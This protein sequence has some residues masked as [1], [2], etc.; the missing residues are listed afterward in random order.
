MSEMK[1]GDMPREI[2]RKYLIA[3][4]DMVKLSLIPGCEATQIE[5][6]YLTDEDGMSRRVRKR[7]NP[8]RGYAFTLTKKRHVALGERIELEEEITP[9]QFHALLGEAHPDKQPVRKV[10]YCFTFRKQVFELDV[11]AF[12]DTLATLEIE[13]PSIDT[14]VN[15]PSF[16]QI[17]RDVTDDER[18]SNYALSE[19]LAFPELH[20]RS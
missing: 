20:E 14:P 8:Q 13:L 16:V 5:Q 15:L 12:S 2:E 3:Y 19:Q 4:P 6:I 10:R 7:G 17:I 9:E 18:F 11:Y 1:N